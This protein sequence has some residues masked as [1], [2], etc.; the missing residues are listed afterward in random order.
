MLSLPNKS[1]LSIFQKYKY[2]LSLKPE[3]A[4]IYF[5]KYE[6]FLFT[7]VVNRLSEPQLNV[8]ENSNWLILWL[9]GSIARAA[10][11]T[12]DTEHVIIRN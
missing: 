2:F 5:A 9:K 10:E 8:S 7:G 3:I 11:L 12:E 6:Q 1:T 4:G